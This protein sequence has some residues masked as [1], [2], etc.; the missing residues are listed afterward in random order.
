MPLALFPILVLSWFLLFRL[1]Q[2]P[3]HADSGQYLYRGILE[4]SGDRFPLIRRSR[5]TLSQPQTAMFFAPIARAREFFRRNAGGIFP[6]NNKIAAYSLILW[7]AR[8]HPHPKSFRIFFAWYNLLGVLG[9]F[10]LGKTF[11]GDAVGLLAALGFA[12]YMASPYVDS[13][14]TH[15]E[16]YAV[17]FLLGIPLAL[18]SLGG[19][20]SLPSFFLL[21][22]AVWFLILFK[23]TL[24]F[25]AAFFVWTPFLFFSHFLPTVILAS[26]VALGFF[27]FFLFAMVRKEQWEFLAIFSLAGM[28]RYRRTIAKAH[29]EQLSGQ[30]EAPSYVGFL[31][32]F[33]PLFFLVGFFP[34]LVLPFPE[35]TKVGLFLLAWL[36]TT[37]LEVRVQGQYFFSHL[38]PVLLPSFLIAS[39]S[40]VLASEL[41]FGG[42]WIGFFALLL[43]LAFISLSNLLPYFLTDPLSAHWRLYRALRHRHALRFAAS[44]VIGAYLRGKTL[45]KEPVFLWGYNSE[46][47]VH[48]G[49]PG[50]ISFLDEYAGTEP[51]LLE[52]LYGNDWLVWVIE[53][54]K[55]YRPRFIVDLDGGLSIEWLRKF[56]GLSYT[57]DR[58]F[59]HLFPVWRLTHEA[60][61]AVEEKDPRRLALLTSGT[62]ESWWG[63]KRIPQKEYIRR[64]TNLFTAG[65]LTA[66]DW[67]ARGGIEE[68]ARAWREL[69]RVS[70]GFD[71]I[72][73]GS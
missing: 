55:T 50:I 66:A 44:E 73:P 33:S 4:A 18:W 16:H 26:G 1:R 2:Q 36:L 23:P 28:L 69:N 10:L 68:L 39:L 63:G 12:L 21:G 34:L 27:G 49:R 3:L 53:G 47:Y 54:V 42:L 43:L 72:L 41:L 35:F 29:I 61:P 14:Q 11:V 46:L 48:A 17:P 6:W 62:F 38:V 25:Q 7:W 57:L 52:P 30:A 70:P 32:Q 31:K 51:E 19:S 15:S 9:L 58:V 20:G 45:P 60:D 67:K 22:I 59:F 24:L 37:L 5:E 64:V 65:N 71:A 13:H 40:L 8:S 56:T